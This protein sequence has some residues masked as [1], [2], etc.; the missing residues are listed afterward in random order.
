MDEFIACLPLLSGWIL[1]MSAGDPASLPHPIVWFGKAI[2][3]CEHKFNRGTRRRLK[4]AVCAILLIALAYLLPVWILSA[5]RTH[6]WPRHII[7]L[8]T[9]NTHRCP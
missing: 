2:S 3:W 1:D 9:G 7:T 8:G 4:G 6:R 5:S